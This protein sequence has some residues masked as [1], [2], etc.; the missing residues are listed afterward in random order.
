MTSDLEKAASFWDREIVQPVHV[1]WMAEPVVREYINSSFANAWPL[2][3]FQAAY[4]ETRFAHALSIGCGTGAL[5]RDLLN[6]GLVDH[7]DA[8]D[9]SL[10]SLSIAREMAAAEGLQNRVHYFAA[11]FNHPGLPRKSYD[12]VFFHQ[13]LHHVAKLEK[14]LSAVA[15]ALRPGGLVY[16][17]E[18][19]GPSR[20]DW[21]DALMKDLRLLH[22]QIGSD[23]RV[24]DELPYPIMI[25]DPSEAIRSGEILT[26]LK[27]GFRI[28][29]LRG[30]GGNVLSILYPEVRWDKAPDSL[31][32]ELIEADADAQK[33]TSP[34]CAIVVARP[35]PRPVLLLA[36]ARYF[37]E[38]KWRRLRHQVLRRLGVETKF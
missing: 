2:D 3:W 9:A 28:E 24:R 8:F 16:L 6:R 12:A 38:P 37:L 11:D 13:S 25:E 36:R 4:P 10:Q 26:Q 22:A 34:F 20:T 32:S 7:I 33:R 23:W 17:D 19:V 35:K 30:Y 15:G 29:G 27:I 18:Y 21:N 1:S 14:L 31:L 5:E